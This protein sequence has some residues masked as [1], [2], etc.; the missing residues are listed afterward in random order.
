MFLNTQIIQ[1]CAF[2]PGWSSW[3][4]WETSP[5]PSIPELLQFHIPGVLLS[6][7]LFSFFLSFFFF[8]LERIGAPLILP[9]HE[10]LLKRTREL[11]RALGS[12]QASFP[13]CT[14]PPLPSLW[15]L[16]GLFD[17]LSL[18]T[19]PRVTARASASRLRSV[20]L[21]GSPPA[22]PSL[23]P[24]GAR[25]LFAASPAP[26]APPP[27]RLPLLLAARSAPRS[28]RAPAAMADIKTGI[29]AKNVQKRLNRAQEKVRSARRAGLAGTRAG[30]AALAGGAQE[31]VPGPGSRGRPA[32]RRSHC[33]KA[34]PGSRG[35]ADP[36]PE[37]AVWARVSRLP[38]PLRGWAGAGQELRQVRRVARGSRSGAHL[39]PGASSPRSRRRLSGP[40]GSL[41]RCRSSGGISGYL[42]AA[43]TSDFAQKLH[44]SNLFGSRGLTAQTQPL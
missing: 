8:L 35:R 9:Y 18:A 5:I 17:S 36:V 37:G 23:T 21:S 14:R 7:T 12:L 43:G 24:P 11:L 33:S 6:P 42:G 27:H 2:C 34:A 13:F 25:R 16:S 40:G 38:L 29:F 32:L 20:A 28:L 1:G 30:R 41:R 31:A 3:S 44:L 15:A 26:P 22:R 19:P 10:L 4:F 39:P